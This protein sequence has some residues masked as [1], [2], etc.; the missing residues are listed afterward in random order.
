[1]LMSRPADQIVAEPRVVLISG[2]QA[3]DAG[4]EVEF[5]HLRYFVGVAEELHFGRAATRLFITQPG[6]PQSIAKL[7]RALN[8]QLLRR[9]RR[10]VQLTD[11]GREFLHYARRLLADMDDAVEHVRSVT[12]WRIEDELRKL[13][14]NYIQAG[15][16]KGFAVRDGN[17]I[18][19]QQNFSGGETAQLITE[20]LGR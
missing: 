9:S 20:T 10:S 8:V 6:L 16:W 5:R 15:L 17:L 7:E 13:G 18:T 1:M 11:A 3:R 2:S 12:P 19:G 4:P 14:A